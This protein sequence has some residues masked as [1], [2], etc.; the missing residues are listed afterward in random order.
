M[1]AY[2]Q[3]CPTMSLSWCTL[4]LYACVR[5]VCIKDNIY[6]VWV[7]FSSDNMCANNF[8]FCLFSCCSLSS[9]LKLYAAMENNCAPSNV[10]LPTLAT[11]TGKGCRH[12]ATQAHTDHRPNSLQRVIWYLDILQPMRSAYMCL[13]VFCTLVIFPTA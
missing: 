13:V 9:P 1:N 6:S 5:T 2:F 3:K 10:T 4:V 11:R 12:I 7:Q 8:S